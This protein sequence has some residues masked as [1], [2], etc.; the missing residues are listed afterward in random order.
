MYSASVVVLVIVP[1]SIDAPS[2]P[3]ENV[4]GLEG[5]GQVNALETLNV[6]RAGLAMSAV[7]QM[8]GLI[9]MSRAFARAKYGATP[10]WVEWR[11]ERME[12]GRF[13][14]EAVAYDVVGRFEHSGTKSVRMET[15][16]AEKPD[17]LV[18]TATDAQAMRPTLER[19]QASLDRAGLLL[20]FANEAAALI[21]VSVQTERALV[22]PNEP[23]A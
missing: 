22:A 11:L 7:A 6:G 10:D 2:V 1:Q 9:E 8:E 4:L 20:Q 14:A 23:K 17:M 12:E 21:G 18:I 19:G 16:I 3:R 15:A 13:T 5:R